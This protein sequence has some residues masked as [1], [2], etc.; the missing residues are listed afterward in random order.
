MWDSVK[1]PETEY[2][3]FQH[4]LFETCMRLSG[5]DSAIVARVTERYFIAQ[6]KHW[7]HKPLETA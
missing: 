5:G 4:Q 1:E 6:A 7:L 2:G 3:A